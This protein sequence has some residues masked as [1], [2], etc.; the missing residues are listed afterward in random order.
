[1]TIE[2][3]RSAADAASGHSPSGLSQSSLSQAKPSVPNAEETYED[4]GPK[5]PYC[6]RQYTADEGCYFDEQNYTEET[7]DDCGLTFDVNVYTST[8]W[9]CTPRPAIAMD[10]PKRRRAVRWRSHDS[11]GQRHRTTSFK[12][13][14][15]DY[16]DRD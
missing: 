13:H 16:Q 1:M 7:C 3:G 10:G 15:H 2:H 9:T 8:T 14:T 12:E 4:E 6:G 11:A 5:C